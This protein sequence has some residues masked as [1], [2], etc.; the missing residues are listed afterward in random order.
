MCSNGPIALAD[1]TAVGFTLAH[2][3]SEMLCRCTLMGPLHWQMLL[4]I[5]SL[6]PIIFLICA[7]DALGWAHYISRC[8]CRW[9]RFGPLFFRSAANAFGCAHCI[10][11]CCCQWL[12]FDPKYGSQICFRYRWIS[13][14]QNVP[15]DLPFSVRFHEHTLIHRPIFYLN[16]AATH[17]PLAVGVCADQCP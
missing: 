11:E 8:C 16:Y 1:A 4:P 7:D 15:L 14:K 3:F 12:H 2:Y 13:V 10:G 5:A 17:C 9:L 6:R